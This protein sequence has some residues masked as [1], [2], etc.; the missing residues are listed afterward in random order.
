[1]K[2][3]KLLIAVVLIAVAFPTHAQT[4]D[5]I[6]ANYFENTGGE[7]AWG[8]LEGIQINAVVNQGFDIP[9]TIIEMKD[10]RQMIK[11]NLQGQEI[12]QLAFDGEV[13]WTTNFQSMKSEKVDSETLENFKTLAGKSF[14]SPFLNYKEKGFSVELLGEELIDGTN[15]Y[16]VEITMDPVKADG[17][18]VD[19]KITYYFEDENFVPIQTASEVQAGPSKGQIS[20]DTYSDYT[21]VLMEGQS[22]GEGLYFALARTVFGGQALE[23]KSIDLNPKVTDD[24]FA[25]PTQE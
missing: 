7:E 3:I 11:I 1:M 8:K 14:P 10:G 13:A 15:T 6:I 9:V 5:E 21:E 24:M 12:T 2:T 25:F 22:E 20:K 17:E 18:M 4:A 23:I 16:K 19:N